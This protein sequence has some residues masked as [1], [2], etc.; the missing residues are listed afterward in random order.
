M[1]CGELISISSNSIDEGARTPVKRF[2][3]RQILLTDSHFGKAEPQ[4][5]QIE[6]LAQKNLIPLLRDH[7]VV[8]QGFIGSDSWPYHDSGKEAVITAQP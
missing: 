2:D 5:E 6:A 7:I 8:T 3:I 1:A 4:V